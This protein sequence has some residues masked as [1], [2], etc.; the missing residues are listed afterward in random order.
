MVWLF[1][2]SL[3]SDAVLPFFL[4]GDANLWDSVMAKYSE[5]THGVPGRRGAFDPLLRRRSLR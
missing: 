1:T 2:G 4:Q 5:G 3:P